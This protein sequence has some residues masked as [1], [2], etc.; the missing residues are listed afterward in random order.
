MN[1][2][3]VVLSIIILSILILCMSFSFNLGYDLNNNDYLDFIHK[4]H[5]TY[6]NGKLYRP[7]DISEN[8]TH[9]SFSIQVLN[10][11]NIHHNTYEVTFNPYTLDLYLPEIGMVR[12]IDYENIQSNT[13]ITI[14]IDDVIELDDDLI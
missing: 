10:A 4:Q 8:E 14:D 2:E 3:K 1:K 11:S 6:I 7:I 13:K 12:L 5:Y 9:I